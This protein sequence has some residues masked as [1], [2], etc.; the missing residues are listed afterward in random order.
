MEMQVFAYIHTHINIP[1][2]T[3]TYTCVDT[4]YTWTHMFT[5]TFTHVL[6]YI[7]YVYCVLRHINISYTRYTCVC[8]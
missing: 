5:Y 4:G 8:R 2:Y 6:G 7:I 3:P 1:G